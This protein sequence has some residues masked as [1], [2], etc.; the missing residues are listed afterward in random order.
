MG[1]KHEV[2]TKSGGLKEIELTNLKDKEITVLMG[3][4]SA[5]REISLKTGMTIEIS[6]CLSIALIIGGLI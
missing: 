6:I 3:G 2:G 1:V 4:W 5:E